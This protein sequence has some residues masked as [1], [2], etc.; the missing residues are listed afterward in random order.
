MRYLQIGVLAL[1][2]VLSGASVNQG[3]DLLTTGTLTG[4]VCG[5]YDLDGLPLVR[6]EGWD[7]AKQKAFG[8]RPDP[9]WTLGVIYD[10]KTYQVSRLELRQII[11]AR[12]KR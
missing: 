8:C 9:E 6:C 5:S 3:T 4:W 7:Y 1:F 10:K 11:A 12:T 2:Q